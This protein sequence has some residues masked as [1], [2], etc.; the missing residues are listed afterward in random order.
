MLFVSDFITYY[1]GSE[2]IQLP[3]YYT[4][5]KL[6]LHLA[7]S[8]LQGL[9]HLVPFGVGAFPFPADVTSS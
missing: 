2:H 5:H 7:E 1:L 8:N 9:M 6:D 3:N 4:S